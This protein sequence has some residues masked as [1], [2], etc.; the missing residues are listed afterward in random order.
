FEQ[1]GNAST[2]TASKVMERSEVKMSRSGWN[3]AASLEQL[4]A[5]ARSFLIRGKHEEAIVAFGLALGKDPKNATAYIDPAVARHN[6]G[7]YE[8]AILDVDAAL[9]LDPFNHQSYCYRAACYA[10]LQQHDSAIRDYEQAI[11][12]SPRNPQLY[13]SRAFCYEQMALFDEAIADHTRAL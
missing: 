1:K 11:H 9:N 8:K 3:A 10:R 4:L 2:R 5:A 7:S 13:C 12:F 6:A